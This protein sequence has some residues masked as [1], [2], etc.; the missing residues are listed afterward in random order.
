MKEAISE[1]VVLR[2]QPAAVG[3]WKTDAGK[4]QMGRSDA[5]ATENG[6]CPVERK[7]KPDDLNLGVRIPFFFKNILV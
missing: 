4:R 6:E 2:N 7:N 1:R 3:E 5:E